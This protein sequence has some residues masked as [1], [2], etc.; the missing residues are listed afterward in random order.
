MAFAGF[1]QRT[2]QGA[3]QKRTVI[4]KV[5]D[6]NGQPIEGAN[7]W[8]KETSI[9]AT[10]NEK[11]EYSITFEGNY[12]ILVA[13]FVGFENEETVIGTQEVINFQLIPG[14]ETLGE[15]VVVGYGTQ[16][17]ESVVGAI[18]SISRENLQLPVGRLSSG[19][20][21]QVAGIVA[22][23]RSGEPG[24][25][26]NFWIRGISTFG[27]GKTPL[28]L[29]DGIERSLDYVDP[30][31]V[32]SFSVLKDASA[33]AVYGVRGANGVI[34]ITTR[35]GS[36]G[37][38][39]ISIKAEAGLVGPTKMPKM[40]NAPQFLELYN[41]GFSYANSGQKYYS[42]E[43]IAKYRDGVDPDLYPNVNWF[44]EL[45]KDFTSNQRV[46]ANVSGGGSIAR[47]YVSGSF[48]NEGSIFKEDSDKDYK[49]SINY[50][51]F[52]FRSNVD[53]NLHPNT[54]LNVN[55]AN[56][57]ETKNAP[58]STLESDGKTNNG[59]WDYSFSTPASAFPKRFSNGMFSAPNDSGD[60]PYNLLTQSG[61]VEQDWNTAQALIGVTQDFS[62]ITEGLTAN[63]KFSWDSH[64]SRW[65]R[66][67]GSPNTY[68]ADPRGR[69]ENGDLIL[70]EKSK[71]QESLSY[72]SGSEGTR[73]FYLEGSI[74]YS[75]LFGQKH[76]VGGLLLYN[77][78]SHIV[79][80]TTSEGSLPY[81]NQGLAGRLTYA[82]DD[83]Y[84]LD[85]NISYN[86][87]ENFSPG[88]RFG[89][90]PAIGAGWLL[91][92]EKFWKESELAN[93]V[94]VFKIRGTYG[95][96]GNDKIGG[97]RRFI[98][99]PTV[100]VGG[101]DAPGYSFGQNQQ[102]YGGLR[103][104]EIAN[105]NVGWETS[106]ELNI[107]LDISLFRQ[108]DL[109]VE[110]F[111]KKRD[112]IFMQR[113]SLPEFAGITTQ[114]WVNLGKVDNKGFEISAIWNKAFG[115][116]KISAR[117]NFSFN[118]NKV[119]E[120]DEIDRT[121]KYQSS[122]GKPLDQQWGLIAEGLFT[123][124][125]EIDNHAKQ[126][127][128]DVRVGDIRYVDVNG[129]GVVDEFDR[130]AIG[131]STTPEINYSFGATVRWK[132]IDFSFLFQGI[133]NATIQLSGNSIWAFYASNMM[134]ANMYED[135][136][137]KRWTLENP[138]PNAVYPRLSDKQN[139]NNHRASTYWQRD[140][141]LTRLKNVEIGY[142]LPKSLTDRLKM[143]SV[144]FYVSGV[145]LLT[146]SKF[147]LWDPEIGGGQGQAY[148]LNRTI[149]LGLNLNF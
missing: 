140:G 21:G 50:N 58:G 137:D 142:T 65:R 108:L 56:I 5:T 43:T 20:A 125:N 11:G 145:N 34:I 124:Q 62:D 18:T 52:S 24:S 49:S 31:D 147:K 55:L 51:K 87:S 9:G 83:R 39:Q 127:F 136:Y 78:R 82:F 107:G 96:V 92:R 4:G 89:V 72:N 111:I 13:S 105:P 116:W 12:Q 134:R 15:L 14:A 129:D 90:F 118:R 141:S 7:V 98:Y 57:Y 80:S 3:K 130:V 103:L 68:Y 29:V 131:R 112:G 16:K 8:L 73:T 135:I 99:N 35:K 119:I 71:G 63:V 139:Q 94:D 114:P 95:I 85:F 67:Y 33:T 88:K 122:I 44:D 6:L 26:A 109:Q 64:T 36:D 47:Y 17:K 132:G 91:S 148:P 32:A 60:N 25:G 115:E 45:Y 23:Q 110:Y 97:G 1:A 104:G 133:G 30:E 66:R 38:A 77:Q 46:T 149:N 113:S 27:E 70:I 144:R 54:V 37:P 2:D 59:I 121:Y 126:T 138:D 101:D 81:R 117:G 48:Y 42:D 41:E 53:V 76:R 79:Q 40:V 75:R 84:F 61:Y 69:D 86:G 74:T 123:S 100:I 143:S 102:S 10:T 120:R 22:V 106:K 19:L 93:I 128:G 28:V 146:F